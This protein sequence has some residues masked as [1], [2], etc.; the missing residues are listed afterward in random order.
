MNGQIQYCRFALDQWQAV[1][2]S[3]Q[4]VAVDAALAVGTAVGVVAEHSAV[5]VAEPAVVH[6]SGKDT[7]DPEASSVH[8]M[9]VSALESV[10]ASFLPLAEGVGVAVQVGAEA[11][12]VDLVGAA[13]A[14]EL[15][16]LAA[17][18]ELAVLAAVAEQS[19]ATVPAVVV[20][21]V[22]T[23]QVGAAQTD[24]AELAWHVPLGTKVVLAPQVAVQMP[25]LAVAAYSF[26]E[27]LVPVVPEVS[28]P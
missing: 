3:Y 27:V 11:G 13:A 21:A 26:P 16:V 10:K 23:A 25:D 24:P 9:A 1:E 2:P 12:A 28:S 19:V 15:A 18:A 8:S 20:P 5:A 4:A 6:Y 14:A 22:V 17:V 7:V